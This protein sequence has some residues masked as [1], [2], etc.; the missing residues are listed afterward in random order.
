[1]RELAE[2]VKRG[3]WE[4]GGLPV[5][6]PVMSLGETQIEPTLMLFRK[7][8]A[9]DVEEGIRAYDIDG[10][11]LLDGCNKT[12][13]GQLMLNGKR[14]GKDI[15]SGTDV[16]KFSEA[17]R[18][19]IELSPD[20]FELG[21]DIPLRV[22]CM[23]SGKYL[24]KDFCYAGGMPDVLSYLGE[25][26]RPAKT[27]MGGGILAYAEGAE[28][29]K[30]DAI[31]PLDNPL[32]PAAGPKIWWGNIAPNGAI[33]KT[34]T[35]ADALLEHEGEAYVFENIEDMKADNDHEEL[36]VTA[37]TVQV[38]KGWGPKE[39]PDIPEAG[40][41]PIPAWLIK[42]GARD[43][44]RVSAARMSGVAYGTVILHVSPV[45][46]EGGNFGLVQT[47]D[48]LRL[49]VYQGTLD[50]MVSEEVLAENR[51]ACTRE[52]P[53]YVRGYAKPYIDTVLQADKG[54]DLNFLVGND[55]RPVTWENQ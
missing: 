31:R 53:H 29:Y 42:E 25:E 45:S 47:G 44:V 8:L 19:G 10:V 40:N 22:N 16:W 41:M 38:L 17:G 1:M 4:A 14:K 28:C 15:G 26:F 21:A 43:V 33:V 27:V 39:Y 7:P 48:R 2:G 20:G 12:T 49:S 24:M 18:V 30:E 52:P 9:M 23:P 37:N 55:T 54:A 46:N 34:S 36:P 6:F 50:V 13:P 35:A 5:E 3:V 32:R 51:A 11:V